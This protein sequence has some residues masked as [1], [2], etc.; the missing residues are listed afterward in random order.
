MRE[1][2]SPAVAGLTRLG[3]A[4][5]LVGAFA[6]ALAQGACGSSGIPFEAGRPTDRPALEVFGHRF[7]RRRLTNGLEALAVRESGAETVS[8]YVVYAVGT[9]DERPEDAGIAHLT[10]HLLFSGTP[11]TP[12]GAHEQFVVSTGGEA[13]AY[14]RDD[15]TFYYDDGIP[16]DTLRT[17]LEMEADRM[18][19]LSFEPE[20]VEFERGRLVLE[21]ERSATDRGRREQ[22][23]DRVVFGPVSYGAQVMDRDGF[24]LAKDLDVERVRAF[25]DRFYQPNRAAVVVAGAVEPKAAL[26]AIEAAFGAL[27]A[28]PEAGPARA[29]DSRDT[30]D[31]AREAEFEEDLSARRIVY[32]WRGPARRT[33]DDAPNDR[34]ALEILARVARARHGAVLALAGDRLFT[35]RFTLTAA[36]PN[37]EARI[38]A[39]LAS[40]TNEPVSASEMRVAID[41]LDREWRG[42]PLRGRPYFSL[43]GRLGVLSATGDPEYLLEAIETLHALTPEQIRDTAQ[44]WLRPEARFVVRF[45]PDGSRA[46]EDPL[47]LPEDPEALAEFAERAID[48]GD[49]DAAVRAYA[50]MAE[51][52]QDMRVRV[53]ALYTLAEVE[54]Q[55]GNLAE[56]RTALVSAL[57]IVEY[58]A[59]R[60]LL[61]EV[62]T[63][64]QTG[65]PRPPAAEAPAHPPHAAHP[66]K[67]ENPHAH[68]SQ[69]GVANPESLAPEIVAQAEAWMARVEQWR[70]LPFR[71][72]LRIEYGVEGTDDALAGYYSPDERRLV[73]M[74]GRSETFSSGTLLH[75][76]VHALQD[77]HFG[78]AELHRQAETLDAKRALAALIE[79]EAMLAV[80][81]LMQYDFLSHATLFRSHPV[82]RERFGKVFRYAEGMR[83]V[84][85]L[86]DSG[87][88]ARVDEAWR[89]PPNRT[90]EVMQPA[91]WIRSAMSGTEHAHEAPAAYGAY[92]LCLLLGDDPT[93]QPHARALAGSL[94]GDQLTGAGPTPSPDAPH[95]WTIEFV[96]ARSASQFRNLVAHREGVRVLASG[97]DEAHVAL[98]L[99]GGWMP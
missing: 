63:E 97:Q 21:E 48:S 46:A 22:L 80:A 5:A 64:L 91:L 32:A 98:E 38:E 27:P 69:F 12:N 49:V 99:D 30:P 96:D 65:R 18:R 45:E 52:S 57:E 54:R 15:Y 90:V 9:R 44:R 47:A 94:V 25:Y 16:A 59:V 41:S 29:D 67:T 43:A 79:G 86:R 84:T 88:W 60:A 33:R 20:A 23:V 85:A 11:T 73:V 89:A 13:N 40:L 92:T 55:R 75:E 77:Q 82:D 42:A 2:V 10:E 1:D 81:D 39:T 70:G 87:G 28:G 35:D 71:E 34:L 58:P 53:I 78:L 6:L 68:R 74:A 17:V 8:I 3:A 72:D 4:L 36:G 7:E 37:A 14:T 24:T 51:R 66:Q 31:G 62:E 83:F 93:S 95:R 56:A 50:R 26:D 61:D 76:I 19:S